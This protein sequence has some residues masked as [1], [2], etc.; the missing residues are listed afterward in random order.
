MAEH[1]RH[2]VDPVQRGRRVLPDQTTVAQHRHSIGDLVHLVEE[3]RHEQDRG[4]TVTQAA[5]HPEQFGDLVGVEAGRRF[6]EDQHAGGDRGGARD[7]DELLDGDRVGAEGGPRIDCQVELAEQF[8]GGG[9]H[10]AVVDPAE[11]A[12]LTAQQNVLGHSQIG[13]EVDLLVNGADAGVLRLPRSAEPLLDAV[14]RDASRV[15]VV[16]AGERLD[17]RRLS[18]AVL[19][20]QRMDLAGQ[21][22]KSTPSSALTPGK[23]MVTFRITTTGSSVAPAGGV[24]IGRSFGDGR[25]NWSLELV[26]ATRA[27]WCRPG[28]P[29]RHRQSV[30]QYLRLGSAAA[31]CC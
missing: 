21:Q 5:H 7:G 10:R 4:A 29:G 8:G 15:D 9:V 19:P 11:A 18:G 31:A 26:D 2:Q 30:G 17:Q 24:V 16:D 1:R 25:W 6:V 13:A 12:G 23:S 27:R 14:D 22:R 20:H 28:E 3:V